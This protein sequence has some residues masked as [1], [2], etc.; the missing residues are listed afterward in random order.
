[1]R[2]V[3]FLTIFLMN[4]AFGFGQQAEFSFEKSTQRHKGKAKEGELLT[5][6][7]KFTNTGDTPL[8][9]SDYKVACPCTKAHYPSSPVP[10]GEKASI[11]VTF[12]TKDK[13]GY[14]DRKIAI[15]SNAKDGPHYIR[16]KVMVDN[17]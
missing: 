11:K 5:F 15:H 14:Q 8:I 13:I 4:S 1:M 2:F 17:K 7:Y 6:N 3:L 10:P 9:I 16:F 12:D